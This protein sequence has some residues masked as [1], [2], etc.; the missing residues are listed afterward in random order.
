MSLRAVLQEAVARVEFAADAVE[1]GEPLLVQA[2]LL[3][4]RDDL[5]VVL[6]SDD[7][8]PEAA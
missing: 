3:D 6:A 4:L 2:I 7:E 8:E 1:Q 5:L